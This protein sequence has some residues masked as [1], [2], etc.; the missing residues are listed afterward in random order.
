M[1]NFL[2]CW[3]SIAYKKVLKLSI[4]KLP[5]D[6]KESKWSWYG[7]NFKIRLVMF[8]I[9]V[10]TEKEAIHSDSW[11]L[12]WITSVILGGSGFSILLWQKPR[13]AAVAALGS[14]GFLMCLAKE[15]SCSGP[16]P[17]LLYHLYQ[18]DIFY[19]YSCITVSEHVG[20]PNMSQWV[21]SLGAKYLTDC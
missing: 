7:E 3:E 2:Y 11:H 17:H 21:Y 6:Y 12:L 20:V 5:G 1:G 8:P 16:I 19:I 13:K 4:Y 18:A 9:C 14:S 10:I 15:M